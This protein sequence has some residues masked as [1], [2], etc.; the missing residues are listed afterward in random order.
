[1]KFAASHGSRSAAPW[2]FIQ[3]GQVVAVALM[4]MVTLGGFRQT[5]Q[6]NRAI[7]EEKPPVAAEE[8]MDSLD[9]DYASEMPRIPATEPDKAIAT[10]TVAPGFAME[11]LAS[12]PLVTDPIALAFDENLGLYAVEMRGYSENREDDLSR[13]R[14]LLDDNGDGKYD[15][16]TIFAKGLRWPTA[17]HCWKGGVIVADAPDLFYFRDTDGDGVADLKEV[18]FTGF[19][20]GNVQGLVNSFQWGLDNRI[21]GATSSSGASLAR[22]TP[23]GKVANEKEEKVN[24]G[25]RDFALDAKSMNVRAVTGGAQHGLS[26]NDYGQRFICHNSDHLIQVILE[27][28]YVARNPLVAL[29]P[30]RQSIAADGPQADVFRTSPVEPWRIVRTRLRA[31]KVVPGL[32][33]G[34]G[35]PAG[36]FT[37]ATGVTIYRGNA[38]DAKHL[39]TAI[40][41]DVGSNIIHRKKLTSQ[42]IVYRGERIDDKAEFVAS[43]DN[44]FRPVQFA[45]SPDGSLFVCD[46]YRETIEH[47]ASIPPILKKHVDLTSGRDRGRI[48]RIV[49]TGFKQPQLEKLGS[50]SSA[51]LIPFLAHANGW[52]RD[53]AA[54]LLYE[55]Q[56]TSVAPA[57]KQMVTEGPT[58]LAKIHALHA[59]SGLGMLNA[60]VLIVGLQAKE[61]W[62]RAH[63][64]LLAEDLPARLETEELKRE[65]AN[66]AMDPALEVRFQLAL[67]APEVLEK[68]VDVLAAIALKDRDEPYVQAAVLSSARHSMGELLARLA[69]REDFRSSPQGNQTVSQL[70][71]G[72]AKLPEQEQASLLTLLTTLMKDPASA[73]AATGLCLALDLTP[74]S[75]LRTRLAAASP[76][77]SEPFLKKTIEEALQRSA[78][79]NQPEEERLKAIRALRL[80]TL[81][82]VVT[83][84][85]ERLVPAESSPIQ[86]EALRSM[87]SFADAQ[88]AE[89]VLAK[90]GSFS[91]KLKSQAIEALLSRAKW[92]ELLLQKVEKGEL[93]TGEVSSE[94]WNLLAQASDESVKKM[95]LAVLAKQVTPS[96]EELLKQYQGATQSGAGTAAKGQEVFRKICANCHRV[97]GQGHELGPNLAAMRNR[98]REA[99]VLNVLA[100]NREVNPQYLN[101]T[102]VL[103]DGRTLQGMLA[104]ETATSI[105]LKRG[106]GQSDTILRSEIEVLRS[107]GRSL[108]PEGIEKQVDPAS[109]ADLV[110]YLMSL[111]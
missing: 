99:I 1:M 33:E 44:W 62:V 76:D 31:K 53:T 58:Q 6:E 28:R 72:I 74:G 79:V 18:L 56:D 48:Y 42:G 65:L 68:P 11:L 104:A 30:A 8:P 64:I 96:L 7:A 13:I 34:G 15:R 63:A 50:K 37:S 83:N 21:Y 14:Y 106:E 88:A 100:P 67:S 10:F 103:T 75:A 78:D 49:P 40:V 85:D 77:V 47:P 80:G 101:Y 73:S 22:T 111:Q 51:E 3:R 57:L 55:R 38:W 4:G 20:V 66:R 93:P 107:T 71:K 27:D 32:V 36:Y 81:L 9:R 12:E 54:R 17:I 92:R 25:G 60:E 41:G 69:T 98:G 91:P 89:L 46:M 97:Q 24:L 90:L 109:M 102:A 5:V 59:L 16:S 45:N 29:P 26:V 84:L 70:A 94:Q 87:A 105:T 52:H 82:Q 61:A 39:G 23:E 19:G 2:R 108:M 35:R 86:A 95:A 110:A 43:T